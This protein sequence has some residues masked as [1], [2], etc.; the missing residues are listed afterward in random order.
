MSVSAVA[1]LISSCGWVLFL[2]LDGIFI[3]QIGVL[4]PSHYFAAGLF[5]ATSFG[6]VK[7]PQ[8]DV[9]VCNL[10]VAVLLLLVIGLLPGMIT[11]ASIWNFVSIT[12]YFMIV[13]CLFTLAAKRPALIPYIIAALLLGV[14]VSA[15]YAQY[16][17]FTSAGGRL[18]LAP[19]YNPTWFAAHLIA[20]SIACLFFINLSHLPSIKMSLSAL[21]LYFLY[22]VLMSQSQTAFYSVLLGGAITALF[23]IVRLR[24]PVLI[25]SILVFLA[26]SQFDF[27]YFLDGLDRIQRITD[28]GTIGIDGVTSG[29]WQLLM[30]SFNLDNVSVLGVGWGN[31]SQVVGLSSPHN[32]YAIIFLEAGIVGLLLFIF[33][34]VKLGRASFLHPLL[35][36]CFVF[37]SIFMFGND[38][39]HYK[40]AWAILALIGLIYFYIDAQK[41]CGRRVGDRL[42]FSLSS[43]S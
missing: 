42:G 16:N 13:L 11:G 3:L 32:N 9:R 17:D 25:I 18:S 20:G 38:M 35:F 22:L 26:L 21:L 10:A 41:S 30:A 12:Y 29:R 5:I 14:V 4:A 24:K 39:I 33:F 28:A 7:D 1:T 36:F 23:F 27:H 37:F 40:Y 43:I 31:A 34:Q 19:G 6:I 2:P 8:V 15:L